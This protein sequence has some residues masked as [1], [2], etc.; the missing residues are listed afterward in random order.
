MA[1][2]GEAAPAAARKILAAVHLQRPQPLCAFPVHPQH[3]L[4]QLR[5]LGSDPSL[6]ALVSQP[7]ARTGFAPGLSHYSHLR[8][9]APGVL[10]AQKV[11]P[12]PDL[13]RETPSPPSGH[14]SGASLPRGFLTA[15]LLSCHPG[16]SSPKHSPPEII[17]FT[18]GLTHLVPVPALECQPR[19][20]GVCCVHCC[21]HSA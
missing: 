19:G 20:Q 1:Q 3:H 15:L 16:L 17:L 8:A 21:A 4:C 13:P 9:F 6:C 7:V 14:R 18:S 10:P 12:T 11:L 2:D 5:G